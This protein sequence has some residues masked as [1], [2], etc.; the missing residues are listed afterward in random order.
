MMDIEAVVAKHILS[1][2]SIKTYVEKPSAQ[3]L[4]GV[5]EYAVV[6]LTSGGSNIL[7]EISLDIDCYAPEGARKTAQALAEK[8]SSAVLSLD[9]INS[10]F[11]PTVENI[12][13]QND[14][15]TGEARYIVQATV[16]RNN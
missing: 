14:P 13:R 2:T 7:D 1:T 4:N 10:L 12:Y 9:T 16:Y 5:T 6:T 3:K 15:D 8:V 11:R